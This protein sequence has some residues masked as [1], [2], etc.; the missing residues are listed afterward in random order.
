MDF[1]VRSIF[2]YVVISVSLIN[3]HRAFEKR[4]GEREFAQLLEDK[5][6]TSWI[7]RYEI[8]SISQSPKRVFF[9]DVLLKDT[10]VRLQ[11]LQSL[12]KDS[13]HSSDWKVQFPVTVSPNLRR[14][15]VLR[16]V[17]WLT[18]GKGK[19]EGQIRSKTLDLDFN[20]S[21]KMAWDQR[22]YD[23][24]QMTRVGKP[25]LY[26]YW[27]RFSTDNNR[28]FFIDQRNTA[29]Y[30]LL[31]AEYEEPSLQSFCG[32]QDYGY[33]DND[34]LWMI[35]AF[36]HPHKSVVAYRTGRR[37]FIWAF[38]DCKKPEWLRDSQMVSDNRAARS[39][40]TLF[41]ETPSHQL[42]YPE[43]ISFSSSSDQLIVKEYNS[44]LALVLPLPVEILCALE[45]DNY[46]R[47]EGG[48]TERDQ[49]LIR[50]PNLGLWC[51]KSASRSLVSGAYVETLSSSESLG[52]TPLSSRRDIGILLWRNTTS[53]FE[54]ERLEI[55]KLPA[56]E[57]METVKTSVKFPEPGE[58]DITVILNKAV[59]PENT[60]RPAVPEHFPVVMRREVGSLR[61]FLVDDNE[62][63][64]ERLKDGG[65]RKRKRE[66]TTNDEYHTIVST[67]SDHN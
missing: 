63:K 55:V 59:Q 50:H 16:T 9:H 13:N 34:P 64:R 35:D 1:S 8:W 26:T 65:A 10:E 51:F 30:L 4:Q 20:S 62:S 19:N 32:D 48:S 60:L 27:I 46:P 18:P 54:Q 39:R 17:Y 40:P 67:D 15:T 56:W 5:C 57:R 47:E 24:D 53:G 38:K 37:I 36:F 58:S 21:S 44:E 22:S 41:Y 66:E 61:K 23:L 31:E 2:T 29:V 7:A 12:R 49:T 43:H 3:H 25:A 52:F 11:L 6:V 14:F 33:R 45:D 42:S 28:I